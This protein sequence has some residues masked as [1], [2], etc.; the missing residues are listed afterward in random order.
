M[1]MEELKTLLNNVED[2]YFDF[3]S[4]MLHYAEKKESRQNALLHYLH[5]HPNALSSEIIKFVSLQDDFA[6]DAAYMKVV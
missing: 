6:E 3:V 1:R 4:A 2:S 5:T